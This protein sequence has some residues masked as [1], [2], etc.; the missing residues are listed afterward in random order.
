MAKGRWFRKYESTMDNPKVLLLSDWHYRAWDTL[1]CFASKSGGEFTDDIATLALVL[2]KPAGKIRDTMQ[3]MLSSGLMVKTEKGYKPHQWDEFQ[4]KSDVSTDRVQA[5]RKQRRNVSS[6]VTETPPETEAETEAEKKES[7]AG[8]GNPHFEDFWKE[9]PTHKNMSK[10][11]ARAAWDVLSIEQK[12]RAIAA[13]PGFRSYCRSNSW[14]QPAY[15]ESFLLDEKFESYAA[16][17]VPTADE[18]MA[19]KDRA[20]QLLR[21]GKYAVN[22]Q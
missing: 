10:K 16:E 11:Q 19:S 1:L 9:Y 7:P 22:Y 3:V 18:I 15:A 14:Y 17:Q 2:R 20:D 4:Y 5:F 21:R 13:L 12:G 8:A 6:S